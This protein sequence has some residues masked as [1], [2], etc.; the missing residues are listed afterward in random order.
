MVQNLIIDCGSVGKRR[1]GPRS[2]R[3]FTSQQQLDTSTEMGKLTAE[4][5]DV[6]REL[7][8]QK[9]LKTPRYCLYFSCSEDTQVLS[10][11]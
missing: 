8:E 9:A 7:A 3:S 11:F 6:R 5:A 2:F 10:L 1:E 4:L